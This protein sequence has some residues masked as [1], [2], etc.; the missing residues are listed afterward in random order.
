MD[1][2]FDFDFDVRRNRRDRCG[3][4]SKKAR[5]G[6]MTRLFTALDDGRRTTTD[7]DDVESSGDDERATICLLYTSPSPRDS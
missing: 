4:K 5:D 6:P 1:F 3:G 2:D 7:D